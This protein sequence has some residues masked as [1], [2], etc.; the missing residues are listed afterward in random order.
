VTAA[1]LGRFLIPVLMMTTIAVATSG[2]S[3]ISCEEE[4]ILKLNGRLVVFPFGL[5]AKST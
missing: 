2:G 4:W 5:Y 1:G 3:A